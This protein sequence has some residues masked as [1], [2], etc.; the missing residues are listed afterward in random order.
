MMCVEDKLTDRITHRAARYH[1]GKIMLVS[2]ES[3]HADRTR[4]SIRCDLYRGTMFVFTRNHGGDRPC[5]CA[6][7]G[8]KRSAA[9]EEFTTL[10]TRHRPR[11]LRDSF[12][13]SPCDY[14]VSQCFCTQQTCL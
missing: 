1:V 11:T 6:V 13:C 12:E 9:V 2:R 14:T 7:T 5:L 8:R 10:V 3:R 4:D